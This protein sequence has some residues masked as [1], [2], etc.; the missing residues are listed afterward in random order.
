MKPIIRTLV[1]VASALAVPACTPAP[2]ITPPPMSTTEQDT[3]AA[4]VAAQL[5]QL[6]AG[7]SL[8]ASYTKIVQDTYDKLADN[9]KALYLFL[10]AIDCYLK[11]GKAGR[12]VAR[13]MADVVKARWSARE[14][15]AARTLSI[16][17]RSPD[18][19][20]KIHEIMR[21]VGLE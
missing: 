3:F 7:G 18:V 1:A 20:P 2:C 15:A 12:D 14:P 10:L 11:D 9:D 21:R 5:Q 19:A 13:E 8:S 16:D 4:S 6:Q 17:R